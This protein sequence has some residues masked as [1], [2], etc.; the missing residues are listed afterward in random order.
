[1][2]VGRSSVEEADEVIQLSD[3]IVLEFYDMRLHS[4]EA[5]ETCNRQLQVF[6]NA[7]VTDHPLHI[8]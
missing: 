4:V 1:M 7:R 8:K 6:D 5:G 3:I 2:R